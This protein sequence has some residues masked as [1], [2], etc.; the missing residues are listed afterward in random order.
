M[1]READLKYCFGRPP[2]KKKSD[3][4]LVSKLNSELVMGP[5]G[6]FLCSF[7]VY[8]GLGV[9][10]TSAQGLAIVSAQKSLLVELRGPYVVAGI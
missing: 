7:I 2:A 8:F 6:S 1:K 3:L 5:E 4:V 10:P 9:T